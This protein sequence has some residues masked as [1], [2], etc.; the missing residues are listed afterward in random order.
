MMMMMMI[1]G[2]HGDGD[3]DDDDDENDDGDDDDGDDD[4][5]DDDNDDDNDDDDDDNAVTAVKKYLERSNKVHRDDTNLVYFNK[6]YW[7]CIDIVKTKTVFLTQEKGLD[8][9][10]VLVITHLLQNFRLHQCR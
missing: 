6:A 10:T 5:G 8:L 4:D 9:K 1:D 3:D 7:C 2:G